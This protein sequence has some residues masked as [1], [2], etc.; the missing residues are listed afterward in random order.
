MR[1]CVAGII[2]LAL[3]FGVLAAGP[4]IAE[5]PAVKIEHTITYEAKGTRSEAQQGQL[6]L[7]GANVPNTFEMVL[8][9][10]K[11]FCFQQRAHY[12][13]S[14]G[15]W[16]CDPAIPPMPIENKLT[17]A[18]LE[19]GWRVGQSMP[20]EMPQG[21]VHVQWHD[22]SAWA[23]ANALG[24]MAD[25]LKLPELKRMPMEMEPLIKKQ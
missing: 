1:K 16:P 7:N 14:Y 12:W 18:E 17:P 15:Y 21:W 11:V 19:Q 5:E 20:E 24:K 23:A 2:G 4:A 8:I 10:D 13:G 3:V 25:A 6:S 22:G 9:G